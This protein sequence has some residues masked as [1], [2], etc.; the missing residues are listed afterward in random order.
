MGESRV[1]KSA[2]NMVAGFSYQALTL[3]LSFISRTVFIHT[4]GK[5]YLGLNGIFGDVLMLLSMADL[6]F[7][8]AMAYSFYKPL[9]EKDEDRITGLIVF[10]KKVY[11][12]IAVVV[13][14]LGLC[15]IP[16]LK[17]I[18]KTEQEIPD[19]T[20]YY[21]FSLANVVMSYLFVY[22]TTLLTADQKNYLV[23]KINMWTNT[24]KTI[25]QIIVL[26]I[27]C[28]YIAYL[29]IGVIFQFAG[30]YL[31]SKKT[32]KEYP[33]IKNIKNSVAID[34]N[35]Q[36]EIISNMKSV[37]IY[38]IS[39]TMFSATD[40]II[41][42]TIVGTAA[43]GLYSNYLMLSNKLLLIEQIVF[44]ALTAS[45]GN[46]IVKETAFKRLQIFKAMQSA[47]FIFCGI[48]SCAFCVMVN[49]L[50]YVWLGE[51]FIL[52]SFTVAAI[53]INTY[54]ACVLQP[55]WIY[56]DATG[57]Y[58]KT[59][60]IMLIGA[61]LNIVLSIILGIVMGITGVILASAIA[62]L[63]TYFWYEPKLLFKEYFETGAKEYFIGFLKNVLLVVAT[64]VVLY[65]IFLKFSVT[66]W[67][68]F[69]IKGAITG[70]VCCVVF[71]ACYAKTEGF[72]VIWEK[73]VNI[74][75]KLKK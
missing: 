7:S 53:T 42:S 70:I 48:I 31:A 40:N 18:V 26:Y 45:I 52:S 71:M 27:A 35:V 20:I 15:C 44:S 65:I 56:R 36:N 43:V 3:I 61:I 73:A 50:I 10:Y 6:G 68:T 12:I 22:K 2:Q 5:E 34:K 55:L 72:M 69:I 11:N 33:Y 75:K 1:K 32:E 74:F 67:V 63:S 28:N 37:F 57:I 29:A 62:R 38:K 59:K 8:T 25:L 21:L 64:I 13:L 49:D 41:I 16:F 24:L 47:S 14:I 54:L 46:I 19:L 39:G 4:L 23:V 60:Y 9:A 66:G 58:M 17:Y 30:N 51:E